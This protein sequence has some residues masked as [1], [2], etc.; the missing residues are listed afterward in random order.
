[1][2]SR[3]AALCLVSGILAGY[4]VAGASVR[5]QNVPAGAPVSVF[6]GDDVLLQFERGTFLSEGVSSIRCRVIAVE[7][8]WIKCGSGDGFGVDR[9]QK[10][11]NL[12]YVTQVTKVEK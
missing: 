10:W 2:L 3:T 12:A 6:G 7:G 9:T 1:M 8:S 5:A 4:L 11:M